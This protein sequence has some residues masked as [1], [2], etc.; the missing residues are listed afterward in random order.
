MH[1]K[2]NAVLIT[3]NPEVN[4]VIILKLSKTYCR[5]GYINSLEYLWKNGNK[6]K[7]FCLQTE[8]QEMPVNELRNNLRFK[9]Q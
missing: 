7:G 8:I 6:M 1:R 5:L 4:F 2:K 9:N 3:F